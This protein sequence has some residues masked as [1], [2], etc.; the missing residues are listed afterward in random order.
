MDLRV[1]GEES[2]RNWQQKN[3]PIRFG[4][5]PRSEV[6]G[7]ERSPLQLVIPSD[8]LMQRVMV[9]V[10]VNP[11][12]FPK[13]NIAGATAL[14]QYLRAPQTQALIH[15]FRIPGIAQPVFLPAGRNNENSVLEPGASRRK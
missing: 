1:E 2:P 5:S 11:K 3:R 15:A 13:T 6:A 7:N 14:E 10:V 4:A 8:S 9:C 12:K